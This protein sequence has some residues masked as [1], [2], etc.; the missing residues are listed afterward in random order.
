MHMTVEGLGRSIVKRA[1]IR[2]HHSLIDFAHDRLQGTET[3][4]Q[5][6]PAD[7]SLGSPSARHANKYEPS[8]TAIF[9]RLLKALDLDVSSFVFVDLG[10]GKGRTLL[11][12]A[13]KPFVRVEGVEIA[14]DLHQ[15][16]LRNIEHAHSKGKPLAPMVARHMDALT[17]EFP[18]EPFVLYLFNPFDAELMAQVRDRLRASLKV[19]RQDC[20][21][22]YLNSKHRRLFDQDETFAELPR[23]AWERA[24]DRL[25][26]PWPFAIYR[27][28]RG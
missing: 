25:L 26:S 10:S 8:P 2:L 3:H 27:G 18:Q 28:R 17:Y 24:I 14:G 20:F 6:W 15:T 12:A 22:I 11:M 5:H 9:N 19:A 1:Q 23:M 7:R 13:E 21:I 4:G 16:A